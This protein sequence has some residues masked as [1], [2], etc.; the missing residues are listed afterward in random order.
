MCWRQTITQF[1][2]STNSKHF[3]TPRKQRLLGEYIVRD[4]CSNSQLF[5]ATHSTDILEGLIAGGSN[6]IRLIRIQRDGSVNRVR[7]LSR[8]R[9]ASISSDPLTRYSGILSGIFYKRVIIAE[10]DSDCLFYNSI[11]RTKAVSGEDHP[12][13][14]F[15][16]AG[17]KHR[18]GALAETLKA[19][20]VPLAVI[21]DLDVVNDEA[22][23][24]RLIESLGGTWSDF[25]THWSAIKKSVE[26]ERP[27]S[28]ADQVKS[29][30]EG[31]LRG[32]TGVEPF[33][34]PTER[35]IK[36]IF[37][38]ISP[39]A[40]LKQSGREGLAKGGTV[41]HF[42]KLSKNCS[43]IGLWLVP[44]G[45][46]EG[47]CPSIEGGHGPSFVEAVLKQRDLEIDPELEKAR[48]FM[49]RIWQAA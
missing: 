19:L 8:Q 24:R 25:E 21:A 39:W 6:K 46:I 40:R 12:D 4:R 30:I 2:F 32:V 7:E 20:D 18:L 28:T 23:F 10:S 17:G 27:P 44:V 36:R 37:K 49:K 13:V 14:L 38:N 22:T 11:L 41:S 48:A 34:K 45:E 9:I 16:H 35:A 33:P 31:E 1:N 15:V 42:D 3:F 5:I 29:S 43:A 26:A 47:F